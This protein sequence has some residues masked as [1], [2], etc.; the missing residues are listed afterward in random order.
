MILRREITSDHEA[1]TAVTLAAFQNLAVSHHTEQFI[2]NA[3]RD[4]NALTISLVAEHGGQIVGHIAFSPLTL[5]DGSLDWYGLGPLSVLPERQKQGIGSA[6]VHEGLSLLKSLGAQGCALVGHPQYYQ[7]FGFK[8]IPGLI[9]EGVP[10][11]F[12]MAL[13]FGEQIANGTVHFH[14]GFSA[15]S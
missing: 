12:F 10:Q 5:S 6:L 15:E 4:A 13:I 3:L 7:R 11:E 9:Y 2:I 8:N 14:P 1:I